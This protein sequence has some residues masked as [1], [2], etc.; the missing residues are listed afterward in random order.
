M[1]ETTLIPTWHAT[2]NASLNLVATLFL[3]FGYRAVRKGR[4]ELHKRLMIAALATSAVFLVSYLI[5]HYSVGSVQ[6]P[7]MDWTR[8]LYL[9]ILIPH[10]ILAALMVPFIL[11]GV[12][13]AFRQRFDRHKFIMRFTW[14]VW[15]FVSIS[16]VLVYLLLYRAHF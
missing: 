3:A 15:M 1:N 12:W 9:A 4:Y 6:Y 8:S 13:F 14:P 2:L 10:V 16:G 11:I 5:Y 7:Y